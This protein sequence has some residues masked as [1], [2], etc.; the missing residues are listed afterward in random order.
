ML[1]DVRDKAPG[2]QPEPGGS[3]GAARRPGP[4]PA[5]LHGAAEG[6]V[7][8]PR[9]ACTSAE[10]AG[11][12][13]RRKPG[14]LTL[15]RGNLRVRG[16]LA[17]ASRRQSGSLAAGWRGTCW[18]TPSFCCC[19]AGGPA[20]AMWASQPMVGK[21]GRTAPS[22]ALPTLCPLPAQNPPCSVAVSAVR[23]IIKKSQNHFIASFF[24]ARKEEAIG[25]PI[26][27]RELGF[28]P[29]FCNFN[30]GRKSFPVPEACSQ[31][32]F[33]SVCKAVSPHSC[34]VSQKAFLLPSVEL[35]LM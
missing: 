35:S 15:R 25:V 14:C 29:K 30:H 4:A 11:R 5:A 20:T 23:Q 19:R 13:L 22:K 26:A 10:A 3:P 7:P 27:F 28:K 31:L 6:C 16:L 33:S 18:S 12:I 17:T 24:M 21:G 2:V 32:P 9:T 8:A 34:T 1:T